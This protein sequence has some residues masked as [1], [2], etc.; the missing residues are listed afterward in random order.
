MIG[1]RVI[2]DASTGQPYYAVPVVCASFN[3]NAN[4]WQ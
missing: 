1:G 2:M 4:T 3:E